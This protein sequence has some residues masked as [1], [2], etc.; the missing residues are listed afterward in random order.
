MYVVLLTAGEASQK[1]AATPDRQALAKLRLSEM[2]TALAALAPEAP[3]VFLGASD[4]QVEESEKQITS[5]LVELIGEGPGTLVAAPWRHDGH[6]DH[7]AAGRAA[8][9]AA[10]RTGAHLVEYLVRFWPRTSPDD[11]PWDR[12][13]HVHLDAAMEEAKAEAIRSHVSQ[14]SASLDQPGGTA[15]LPGHVLAHF[16]GPLEH[17]VVEPEPEPDEQGEEGRVGAS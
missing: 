4:G 7:D 9:E 1:T 15:L 3:L 17:Y 5:S 8:A 11:A 12:L 6:P 2:E 14:V 10:R 16:A 13:R